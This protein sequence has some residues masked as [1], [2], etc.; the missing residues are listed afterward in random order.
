V[1][2][3]GILKTKFTGN[4]EVLW[5]ESSLKA[6]IKWKGYY[7]LHE[8]SSKSATTKIKRKRKDKLKK[9]Q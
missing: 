6:D 3:F 2:E 7:Y 1:K 9:N 5:V 4:K 8:F